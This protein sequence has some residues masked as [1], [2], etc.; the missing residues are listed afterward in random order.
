[1]AAF[2][3]ILYSDQLDRYYVGHTGDSLEERVRKHRSNH[4]GFTG[5]NND[6]QLVYSEKFATKEEAYARERQVKSWKSRKKIR[7]LLKG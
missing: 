4:R 2:F 5:K 1:M 6:W 7:G 3:Y